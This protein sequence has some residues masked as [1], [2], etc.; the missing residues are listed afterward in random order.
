M[1]RT[2]LYI[3]VVMVFVFLTGRYKLLPLLASHRTEKAQKTDD[4]AA[5]PAQAAAFPYPFPAFFQPGQGNAPAPERRDMYFDY[6]IIP[7]AMHAAAPDDSTL[8]ADAVDREV[9]EML[10][11]LRRRGIVPSDLAV[12]RITDEHIMAYTT[13]VL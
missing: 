13:Y 7:A 12:L 4:T 3:I 11:D 2:L 9:N 6:R 5:V 1:D 8:I 10:S